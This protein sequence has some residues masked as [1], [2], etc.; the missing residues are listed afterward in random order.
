MNMLKVAV[1]GLFTIGLAACGGESGSSTST[2]AFANTS[3]I[4]IDVV[5]GYNDFVPVET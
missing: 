1:I 5:Q 2:P 4:Q 3:K